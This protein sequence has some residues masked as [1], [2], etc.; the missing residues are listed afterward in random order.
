MKEKYLHYLWKYK[1]IPF[2][3]LKLADNS[4]FIVHY[5]GDYNAYESG[6]DFLNAII[7]INGI[8]WIGNVELHVKSMDWF[9][10]GHQNDPAYDNVIL[11]VVYEHNGEIN[12]NNS[13]IPTL[14]LKS[15]IDQNHY[16]KFDLLFKS[17]RTILCGS[18]LDKVLP[19]QIISMQEKA[20]VQRL[21][22]KTSNLCEV[23]GS[24]N[25]R[26][27]LY[28]LLARAM[29]TKIN[30]LPFEELTYHLPI[31]GLKSINKKNQALLVQLVSGFA[32]TN[33][34]G[35]CIHLNKLIKTKESFP[36]GVVNRSSWKFGGTRPQNSPHIR[37][38]QFARIVEKFDFEVSFVYLSVK[39]LKTYL[40]ELLTIT[41]G[42][43]LDKKVVKGLTE[44]FKEQLIINCFVPF[45]YWYAQEKE[46]S[47][48][49]EKSFDLL[50]LLKPEQNGIIL[51]WSH[52]GI[53]CK[54]AA[55]SQ[56]NLEIFNEF[57]TRKKCLSC[58]IGMQLL[59]K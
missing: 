23:S 9:Q 5:Q 42:N 40:M 1:L 51:K 31:A 45:M 55:D 15:I 58:D 46:D 33:T 11:H 25:P 19:I 57:C 12:Q 10:H 16:Q 48:L 59:N 43:L 8:K 28:F 24:S 4:K 30:Q 6:P 56:A 54:N 44:S 17:K 21:N 27:I 39:E 22:R 34:A 52:F 7:E 37:I 35:D 41:E 2:H 29:G 50:R 20:L 3:K 13:L 26:Q 38:N 47:K 14:E 36:G 49:L 53:T 18:L 32:V